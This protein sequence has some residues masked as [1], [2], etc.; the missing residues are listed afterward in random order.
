VSL[1]IQPQCVLFS[2]AAVLAIRFINDVNRLLGQNVLV[3]FIIGHGWSSACSSSI[4]MEGL[5]ALAGGSANSPSTAWS[6]VSS[7]ISP[8]RSWRLMAKSTDTSGD[9]VIAPWKLD[10]AAHCVRACF[11]ALGRLAMLSPGYLRDFGTP[12][13][14][15]AGLHCGSVMA[16]EMG[17]VKKEIVF[18]GGEYDRAHSRILPSDRRPC[19][20]RRHSSIFVGLPSGAT[21]R[22]LGD[23]RVRGKESE[24]LLYALKKKRDDR[25]T[26]AK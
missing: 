3:N 5:T 12:V 9:G 1:R 15:R 4:D 7:S 13:H 22:P 11:D 17:S 21:K 20:P 26:I 16:G 24:I 18:L 6:A 23:L 19:L 25:S 2:F 14:C 10:E 8:P